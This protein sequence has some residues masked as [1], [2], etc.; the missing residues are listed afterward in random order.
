MIEESGRNCLWMKET[1]YL[2]KFVSAR[3]DTTRRDFDRAG[4]SF[5]Y[6]ISQ[7]ELWRQDDF[8]LSCESWKH[9]FTE[10]VNCSSHF[11]IMGYGSLFTVALLVLRFNGVF[12]QDVLLVSEAT[13]QQADFLHRQMKTSK[14][15]P[16]PLI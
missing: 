5:V 2:H 4:A 7:K 6:V 9:S 15:L 10:T 8:F 14:T 3:V 16:P 12:T 11:N 1:G 13:W